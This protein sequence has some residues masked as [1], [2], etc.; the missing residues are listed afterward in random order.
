VDQQTLTNFLIWGVGILGAGFVSLVVYLAG[1]VVAQLDKVQRI[2][3][4]ILIRLSILEQ[5][6]GIRITEQ[7]MEDVDTL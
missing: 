5:K 7:D 2:L 4:R 6:A 1:R 3:G